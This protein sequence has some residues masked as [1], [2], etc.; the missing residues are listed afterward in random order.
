MK[1]VYITSDFF[2]TVGGIYQHIENLTQ[3]VSR[4]HEV[5]IIYLNK[6]GKEKIYTDEYKRKIYLLSHKGS[7]LQRFISY[8][9]NK[10]NKIV[11]LEK[12]DIIHVHTLFEAFKI[13]ILSE[14]PM[15]FTNHSSSYLKMYNNFFLRH[16]VLPQIFKK[17]TLII[18]PSTELYQKTHHKNVLMIPNGVNRERFNPDNR[19]KV[20]R[21]KILENLGINYLNQMIILSTRRLAD[22][23][24]ILDF[25]EKNI[26]FFQKAKTSL[27][28]IIIGDGEHFEQIKKIKATNNLDNIYLLGKMENKEI[29]A[30]YYI[31]DIC[32]I[33]S[34]MEA[35]SIS[36]L[37][38]MASGC[39]VISTKVGGL[40]E[41]IEDDING[42]FLKNLL[43]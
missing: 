19:N 39:I 36:A 5:V 22:K 8:P 14:K 25:I 4:E 15:V 30:F 40:A 11:A 29:D 28:Y 26:N 3:F 31:S 9:L 12:P 2:Y 35:I 21:Q 38:A 34:K 41:L 33:P 18:C 7:K 27:I 37:E 24:G 23:N 10:I 32:I 6:N 16:F 43:S 42:K 1:I 17:F 13:K 20:N